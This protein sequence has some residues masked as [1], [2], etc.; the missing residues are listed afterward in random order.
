MSEYATVIGEF[1]VDPDTIQ[2]RPLIPAKAEA[3]FLVKQADRRE[4]KGLDKDGN[5]T[6]KK[7]YINLTLEAVDYPGNIV[8]Q[9]YFRTAA[10][11]EQ[12]SSVISWKKFL[13]KV[14]LPY[15]TTVDDLVN[16]RFRA[17]PKHVGTGDEAKVELE[18]IVGPA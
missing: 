13:D 10:A 16:F 11:M 15:T 17:I 6:D 7:V 18:S 14:K 8:F 5:P 2:E 3:L 9:R 12:K 1:P 4:T